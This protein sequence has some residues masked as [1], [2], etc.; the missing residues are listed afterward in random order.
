M[1]TRNS[2]RSIGIV[3]GVENISCSQMALIATLCVPKC[4]N[5]TE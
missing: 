1:K 4:R 5:M 3:F 2:D